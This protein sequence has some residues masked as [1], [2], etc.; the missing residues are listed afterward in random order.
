MD[1][2]RRTLSFRS[3]KK[4]RRE[5]TESTKP[6]QWQEDERKVREGTCSFQV[7]VGLPPRLPVISI[8]H[9]G[10]GRSVPVELDI[11]I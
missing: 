7:K 10:L 4:K 11:Q 9:E 2:L 1:R 6:H 3:R 8:G 5:Q